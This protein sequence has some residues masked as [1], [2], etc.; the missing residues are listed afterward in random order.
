MGYE[1]P[2]KM[3]SIFR[4]LRGQ[5]SPLRLFVDNPNL[6]WLSVYLCFVSVSV[7]FFLHIKH[8]L[9][10]ILSSIIAMAILLNLYK[11]GHHQF[12]ITLVILIVLW[13]S[14]DYKKIMDTGFE[15]TSVFTFIIWISFVSFLYMLTK[16]CRGNSWREILGL[17]TFILSGWMLIN[18]IRYSF[19]VLGN[20]GLTNHSSGPPDVRR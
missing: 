8:G 13:I 10:G 1:R 7:F 11:V 12:Y 19:K 6:D 4:F 15:L 14:L 18:L 5:F 3:L 2:S 17:P 9:E 20:Y 16:G